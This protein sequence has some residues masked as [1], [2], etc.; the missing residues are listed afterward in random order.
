MALSN[1][2]W[3]EQGKRACRNPWGYKNWADGRTKNLGQLIERVGVISTCLLFALKFFRD[4][5]K[6]Q[7]D[8]SHYHWQTQYQYLN[9]LN[10]AKSVPPPTARLKTT[11]FS[12][13]RWQPPS[14]MELWG[15]SHLWCG[16]YEVPYNALL[17][18]VALQI[19]IHLCHVCITSQHIN[20]LWCVCRLPPYIQSFSLR[21]VKIDVDCDTCVPDGF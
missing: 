3:D 13:S 1:T 12:P 4:Y 7:D 8:S 10:S 19:R 18:T 16:L 15:M 9:H 6:L 14:P 17:L 2:A 20:L 5:A 21:I 11:S